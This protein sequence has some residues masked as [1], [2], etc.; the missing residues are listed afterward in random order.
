MHDVERLLGKPD[1]TGAMLLPSAT[2][3][4]TVWIYELMELETDSTRGPRFFQEVLLV[5]FREDRFDGFLW[6][7]DFPYSL[8]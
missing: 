3:P 2:A 5:F 7:S 4:E 1:G 8:Q 6:F